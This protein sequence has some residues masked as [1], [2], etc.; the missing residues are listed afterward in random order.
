MMNKKAIFPNI[1]TVGNLFCGFFAIASIM[2]NDYIHGAWLIVLGAFFDSLDGWVARIT[3]GTSRFG[4]EFDSLADMVCSG[5]APSL[6]VYKLAMSGAGILGILISFVPVFCG[7]FRLAR[8]NVQSGKK[9]QKTFTGMPI[10]LYSL[11]IASYVIFNYD[12]WG[13][14]RIGMSLVPLMLFLSILMVST[15]P[16]KKLPNLTFGDVKRTNHKF[17]MYLITITALILDIRKTGFPILMSIVLW[18]VFSGILAHF[19]SQDEE[20]DEL[21]E[22]FGL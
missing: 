5:L 17:W 3:K 15:I 11:T 4:M 14:I 10:P 1:F 19:R 13:E 16:Y 7:A 9:Y 12:I 22:D 20:E 21:A 2:N 18:G 6:L 8:F